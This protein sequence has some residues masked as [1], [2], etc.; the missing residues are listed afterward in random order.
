MVPLSSGTGRGDV[1]SCRAAAVSFPATTSVAIRPHRSSLRAHTI[2]TTA[3]AEHSSSPIPFPGEPVAT[4]ASQGTA[5]C[6]LSLSLCDRSWFH[7]LISSWASRCMQ[8]R[9]RRTDRLRRRTGAIPLALRLS[10]PD[11]GALPEQ[12]AYLLSRR[13]FGKFVEASKNCLP[14]AV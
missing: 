6:P 13:R 11:V 5:L 12:N 8:G 9:G 4:A 7:V 14:C 1:G 3:G 2:S 10:P